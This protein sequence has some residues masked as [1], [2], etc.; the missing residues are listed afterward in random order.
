MPLANNVSRSYFRSAVSGRR[1]A[2]VT[3]SIRE[4]FDSVTDDK[5]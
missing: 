2:R 5:T 1:R 3:D 4:M